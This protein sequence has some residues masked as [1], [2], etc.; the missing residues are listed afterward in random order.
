M[1]IGPAE[2]AGPRELIESLERRRLHALVAPDLDDARRLHADDYELIPPGGLP[3][4][5]IEYLG[6]IERGEMVY[7]TFEPASDLAVRAY[8]D[9]AVVRY[10]ARIAVRGKDWRDEGLFWHTDLYERRDGE[11]QAVWSQAT[12]ANR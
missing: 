5:G 8:A 12:R 4:N 11:W 10:L 9:A 7:D 6:L 2:P 3:I 1:S